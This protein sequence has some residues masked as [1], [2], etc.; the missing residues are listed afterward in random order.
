[1]TISDLKVGDVIE[2]R[3]G[4]TT[5]LSSKDLWICK[6]LYGK[7]LKCS[8]NSGYDIVKVLRP[9]YEKVYEVKN[10]KSD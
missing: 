5:I 3:N 6:E 2:Y 8:T 9:L 10:G 7:D 4:K 1:M